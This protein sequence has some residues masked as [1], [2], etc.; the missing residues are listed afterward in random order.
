MAGTSSYAATLAAAAA[1]AMLLLAPA[2]DAAE[3]RRL[4]S[5][6]AGSASSS[7]IATMLVTDSGQV[8]A[9]R[10]PAQA[11]PT[12]HRYLGT[13]AAENAEKS[14]GGK[15]G[16]KGQQEASPAGSKATTTTSAS[17]KPAGAAKDSTGKPAAE[18]VPKSTPTSVAAPKPSTTK[19]A[20]NTGFKPASFGYYG[21]RQH[22]G[23]QPVPK[24]KASGG[25]YK[26]PPAPPPAAKFSA[27]KARGHK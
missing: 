18:A 16:A 19:Q 20:T 25:D 27:A 13:P 7:A 5:S 12:N 10:H 2:A 17:G 11:T 23:M 22:G 9:A 3:A 14:K 4:L 1:L 15:E 26:L 24:P 21:A 6:P 8:G